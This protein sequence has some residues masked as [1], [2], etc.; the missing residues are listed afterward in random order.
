MLDFIKKIFAKEEIKKETVPLNKLDSWYEVRKK[1]IYDR[2]NEEI[3][4]VNDKIINE[5]EK[6]GE[7]II[8]LEKAK[9]KN[10]NISMR[11]KQFMVGNRDAYI[12]KIKIFLKQIELPKDVNSV[13]DFLTNFNNNIESFSKTTAKPYHI[14][15]EF[16]ANES[17]KI[18]NNIGNI[19]RTVKE[20]RKKIEKVSLGSLGGI[21]EQIKKINDDVGEKK[22]N[23]DELKKD[24]T[25]LE[26][27]N[28]SIKDNEKSIKE[29]EESKEYKNLIKLKED[30]QK[31]VDEL[32]SHK[33]TL[34][35]SFSILERA[36]KKYS[37]IC[38]ED[39]K[40]VISYLENPILTLR[41]DFDLK[42]VKVLDNMESSIINNT[43]DLKEK[44]KNKTIEEIR[45]S[46]KEFFESFLSKYTELINKIAELDKKILTSK[47]GEQKDKVEK[48]LKKKKEDKAKLEQNIVNMNKEIEKINIE[49]KKKKIEGEKKRIMNIEVFIS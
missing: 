17:N 10:P 4:V 5:I 29:L 36:L 41:K 32:D 39:E 48:E 46:D 7:N 23:T 21:K 33:E 26:D 8:A 16:F 27:L 18:A 14:L 44:K 31:L 37:K 15:Q 6:A 2:L 40:L 35:H 1:E 30:K 11:E 38:L 49:K 28:K 12:K 24:K 43:I 22:K 13:N 9:L 45:R 3:K 34:N 25:K 19:D 42:I 20:L 47:V